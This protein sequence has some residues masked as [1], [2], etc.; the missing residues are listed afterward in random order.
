[1]A[2]MNH[3]A[4]KACL[5]EITELLEGHSIPYFLMQG[6][7]LGAYRDKGFV[8]TEKDIDIGVLQEHFHFLDV[9]DL[10]SDMTDQGFDIEC[11]TMPFTLPRTVAG[12]KRYDING[13]KHMAK[14]D[15][16]AFTKWKD[17]RFASAPIRND[18]EPYCIVHDA[19]ILEEYRKITLFGKE[20]NIPKDIET[21]LMREYGVGWKIP[22]EDH[23]SRTRIYNYIQIEGIPHDYLESIKH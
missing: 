1:M 13:A 14:V 6:T 11:F 17:T 16:V 15:I 10:L 2:Y 23:I 5:F 18:I 7:A 22:K 3:E 19:N 12:F 9:H 8:P 20:F 4:G 21:Y